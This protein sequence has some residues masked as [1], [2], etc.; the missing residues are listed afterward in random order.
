MK[1]HLKMFVSKFSTNS[2]HNKQAVSVAV[3]KETNYK[4]PRGLLC[5]RKHCHFPSDYLFPTTFSSLLT[6]LL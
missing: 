4:A 3:I 5:K 6:A 2:N 1:I